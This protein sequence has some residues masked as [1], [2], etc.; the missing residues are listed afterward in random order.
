MI[1]KSQLHLGPKEREPVCLCLYLLSKAIVVPVL[2]VHFNDFVQVLG[3]ALNWFPMVPSILLPVSK[4]LGGRFVRLGGPGGVRVSAEGRVLGGS[5]VFAWV[6][7]EFHK[8][9]SY[10]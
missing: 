2:G 7:V 3:L 5:R 10:F 6:A 4:I 8:L 9:L 1:V